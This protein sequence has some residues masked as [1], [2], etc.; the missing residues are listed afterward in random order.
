M[1]NLFCILII[2]IH[3]HTLSFAQSEKWNIAGFTPTENIEILDELE[4]GKGMH[5][6]DHIFAKARGFFS[7]SGINSINNRAISKLKTETSMKGASHIYINYRAI[8]NSW[9]SKTSMYSARIFNQNQV[10]MQEISQAVKDKKI[11]VKMEKSLSRNDWKAIEKEI[12][13]NV[14]ISLNEPLVVRDGKVLIKLKS[15]DANSGK[16]SKG[17]YYEVIAIE[18]NKMLI[19]KEIKKETSFLMYGVEIR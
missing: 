11:V 13:G 1:K 7:F 18:G 5:K 6:G 12:P 15:K 8:E 3:V 17:E 4:D 14:D 16:Y 10:S 2:L 9:F 19:L